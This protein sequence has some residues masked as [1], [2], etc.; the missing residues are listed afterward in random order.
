MVNDAECLA[1]YSFRTNSSGSFLLLALFL[2]KSP[3]DPYPHQLSSP[4]WSNTR[5]CLLQVAEPAA[6]SG[7]Q[8]THPVAI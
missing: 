4:L 3:A 5:S 2:T 6:I 7:S 1:P 8:W